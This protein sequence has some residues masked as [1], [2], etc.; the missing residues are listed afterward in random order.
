MALDAAAATPS[1]RDLE[2]IPVSGD[3]MRPEGIQPGSVM[4][5]SKSRT[6]RLSAIPIFAVAACSTV[7]PRLRRELGVAAAVADHAEHPD[8]LEEQLE[9]RRIVGA[10]AQPVG[11]HRMVAEAAT[12]RT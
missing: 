1:W 4:R 6:L 10:A 8:P 11:E 3:D 7:R 2:R 9:L 5:S 12:K